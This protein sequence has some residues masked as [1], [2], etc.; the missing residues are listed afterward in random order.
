MPTHI[1]HEMKALKPRVRTHA[2]C[3]GGYYDLD[4]VLGPLELD[5]LPLRRGQRRVVVAAAK[6]SRMRDRSTGEESC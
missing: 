6:G 3:D 2:E 5:A 4:G 1:W